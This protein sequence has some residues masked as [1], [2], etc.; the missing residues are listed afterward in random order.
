[1]KKINKI[2]MPILTVGLTTPC[3]IPLTSC[4]NKIVGLVVTSKPLKTQYTKGEYL[5]LTGLQVKLLRK[6]GNKEVI[7]NYTTSI[8]DKS[9]LTSTGTKTITVSYGRTSDNFDIYVGDA[10]VSKLE[11]TSKPE[12]YQYEQNQK[13]DLSGLVVKATYTDD[14]FD[15]DF[16]G[17]TTE[18]A[19]G[20][21]LT[22]WG[23]NTITISA[24]KAT[25]STEVLVTTEATEFSTAS[26]QVLDIWTYYYETGVIDET[27]FCSHF[28]INGVTPTKLTD[29]LGLEKKV[30][31]NGLEHSVKVIGI[32]HDEIDSELVTKGTKALFTFQFFNKITTADNKALTTLYHK[33]DN[34]VDYLNSQLRYNLNRTGITGVDVSWGDSSEKRS[35]FEMLPAEFDDYIWP[36]KKQVATKPLTKTEFTVQTYT[37]RLFL[38]TMTEYAQESPIAQSG[39]FLVEGT[40]YDFWK[41]ASANDR[42][43]T[44]VG[45]SDKQSYYTAT[46]VTTSNSIFAVKDDGAFGAFNIAGT[47]YHSI[48]PC[49]CI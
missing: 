32:N 21:M 7:T 27:T 44:I 34:Y 23:Y 26:W 5:D 14:T 24:D 39:S 12:K 31:I 13:L 3:L 33:D 17:Y 25:T 19:N 4:G 40:V 2:L 46:P 42:I 48:A 9:R 6:N 45:G 18:P 35:L 43:I 41:T 36:V 16:K 49:F 30:T 22:E 8:A 28:K 10:V 20:S 29:F 37:D 11:V 15:N 38:P 47:T 1:M